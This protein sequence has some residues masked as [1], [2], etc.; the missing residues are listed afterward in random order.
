MWKSLRPIAI[1]LVAIET[2]AAIAYLFVFHQPGRSN[3]IAN[4]VVDSLTLIVVIIW[5]MFVLPAIVL[6]V[7][8]RR[9]ELALGLALAALF[10]FAVSFAM[11]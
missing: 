7:R 3:A 1:A 10:V 5:V 2:L 8:G 4:I 6:V 9:I 11:I